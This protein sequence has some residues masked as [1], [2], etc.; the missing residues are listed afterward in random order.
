[1]ASGRDP[2]AAPVIA[3]GSGDRNVEESSTSTVQSPE[4]PPGWSIQRC[5]HLRGARAALSSAD[6]RPARVRSSLPNTRVWLS[7]G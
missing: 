4:V 3:K 6:R 2:F 5:E 7:G 1:M